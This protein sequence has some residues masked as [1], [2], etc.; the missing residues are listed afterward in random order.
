MTSDAYEVALPVVIEFRP[1]GAVRSINL[2]L[3][4]QGEYLIVI[5]MFSSRSLAFLALRSCNIA[6]FVRQYP[7]A[8]TS[9]LALQPTRQHSTQPLAWN[10]T[11]M[12]INPIPD[13]PI[14]K[15]GCRYRIDKVLQE[16]A[17]P[18]QNRVYLATCVPF[19]VWLQISAGRKRC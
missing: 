1:P 12:A 3:R 18:T 8:F 6:S 19:L 5:S 2:C 16:P 7:S 14:G 10:S 9:S 13:E 11:S 17:T 4:Y 15:S